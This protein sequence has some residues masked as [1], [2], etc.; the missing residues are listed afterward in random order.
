MLSRARLLTL[1]DA[2]LA[3]QQQAQHSMHSTAAAAAHLESAGADGALEEDGD[4]GQVGGA[5]A[6][7]HPSLTPSPSPCLDI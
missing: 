6:G 5:P 1:Y 7:T 3:Q 4:L 2:A